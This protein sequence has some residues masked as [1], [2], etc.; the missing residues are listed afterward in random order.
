MAAWS[1][2][3]F[4]DQLPVVYAGNAKQLQ[5]LFV[6]FLTRRF[7]KPLDVR[8]VAVSLMAYND[9]LPAFRHR[10]GYQVVGTFIVRRGVDKIDPERKSM[11]QSVY[12]S[13]FRNEP[14]LRSSKANHG[15]LQVRSP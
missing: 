7:K 11:F 13:L 14:E 3:V 2:Y 9:V 5:T 8:P 4:S 6:E 12:G 15:N 1:P 10:L